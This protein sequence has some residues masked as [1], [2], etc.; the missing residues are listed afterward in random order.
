[1]KSARSTGTCWTSITCFPRWPQAQQRWKKSVRESPRR[2]LDAAPGRC[3]R[4]WRTCSARNAVARVVRLLEAD[5]P[6]LT[7]VNWTETVADE[8]VSM[9]VLVARFRDQ[10]EQTLIRFGALAPEVWRRAGH[11]PE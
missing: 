8:P 1:M 6:E 11:H 9:D 10:R 2:R 5:H 3:A 7:S 4:S